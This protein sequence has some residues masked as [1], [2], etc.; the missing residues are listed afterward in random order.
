MGLIKKLMNTPEIVQ[1]PICGARAFFFP[2]NKDWLCE[3]DGGHH[4][5]SSEDGR[6]VTTHE[7]FQELI[8]P[9]PGMREAS[10]ML[11]DS[12]LRDAS[13]RYIDLLSE[14]IS[15]REEIAQ[16][17]ALV[18][19]WAENS[20]TVENQFE[21]AVQVVFAGYAWRVAEQ[22]PGD[23]TL[24]R[25]AWP[26]PYFPP[27]PTAQRYQDQR[28]SDPNEPIG[29]SLCLAATRSVAERDSL[30][31]YSPGGLV[32]GAE[33][34]LAGMQVAY[35]ALAVAPLTNEAQFKTLFQCGV[36]LYDARW[37]S[38]SDVGVAD[39]DGLISVQFDLVEPEAVF[40][41]TSPDGVPPNL[42]DEAMPS[43]CT[44]CGKPRGQGQFCGWCGAPFSGR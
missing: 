24:T 26:S 2:R 15:V 19:K 38:D 22:E 29:G 23:D 11:H 25:P 28:S 44:E 32:H 18:G 4:G 17:G 40:E 35:V 37:A 31:Q 33:F 30:H 42:P 36:A 41:E 6:L 16:A 13:D 34:L 39:A 43:F 3:G 21:V 14:G 9:D 20:P 1:C 12:R 8:L 7:H 27:P 5:V 10:N